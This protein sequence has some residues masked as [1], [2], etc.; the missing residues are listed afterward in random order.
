MKQSPNTIKYVKPSI[1]N[2]K[3]IALTDY[4]TY[5]LDLGPNVVP[6]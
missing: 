3:D 4:Q 5:L 2:L 1:I 6:T